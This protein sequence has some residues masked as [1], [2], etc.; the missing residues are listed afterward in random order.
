MF[1]EDF[2]YIKYCSIL[3]IIR[4]DCFSF[5]GDC[6]L[7]GRIIIM[8]EYIFSIRIGVVGVYWRSFYF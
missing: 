6:G 1:R 8:R 5:L 4:N 7:R 3:S 2:R